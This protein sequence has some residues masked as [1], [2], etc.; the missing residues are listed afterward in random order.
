MFVFSLKNL[1]RKKIANIKKDI[2]RKLGKKTE[3]LNSILKLKK[4]VESTII[5]FDKPKF[6]KV[7]IKMKIEKEPR[8]TWATSNALKLSIPKKKYTTAINNG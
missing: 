6:S 2:N 8:T 5:F 1:V 3:N 4:I 7:F